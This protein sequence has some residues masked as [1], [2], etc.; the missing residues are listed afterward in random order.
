V[1]ETR[2]GG[3]ELSFED[4]RLALAR[5][6]L[7]THSDRRHAL[8]AIAEASASALRVGRVS[9]WC[10]HDAGRLLRCEFLHEPGRGDV[11]EGAVLPLGDFPRYFAAIGS[12]RVL[13]ISDTTSTDLI[14]EFREPY[15]QPL[16]V[17]AMLDCPIYVDGRLIGIVCHEH[18]GESRAWTS[19]ECECAAAVADTLARVFEEERR[20]SAERAAR[21]RQEDVDRLTHFGEVGRLAA[22][23]A[24]DFNNILASVAAGAHALDDPSLSP[25]ARAEAVQALLH[26]VDRGSSLARQLVD[27]GCTQPRLPRV[28]RL[29]TVVEACGPVLRMAAGTG[30]RLELSLDEPVSR[31]LVDPRDVER[32]LLNLVVNARDAM[33]DGGTIAVTLSQQGTTPG[34]EPSVWLEVRDSGSGMAPEIAAQAFEPYFTTKGARGTGLGLSIV[35]QVVGL[36]GGTVALRSAV[37]SGTTVTLTFPAIG[38]A[39]V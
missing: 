30:V 34:T 4:A 39:D 13:P 36:S 3:P 7:S 15:L 25:E 38:A 14:A 27:L 6:S 1:A 35:Q 16:G 11:F 10:L 28:V 23:M 19:A 12:R 21:V 9:I 22:G 33:P 5:V 37:G 20:V 24:H 26:V 2:T 17:S 32:V 29:Q 31:V 8:R 18:L